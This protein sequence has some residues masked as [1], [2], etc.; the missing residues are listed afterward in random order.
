MKTK[1][2]QV[3][4]DI[5]IDF[6]LEQ[7]RE[8]PRY[9]VFVADELFTER[10]FL[11]NNDYLEEMLQIE[12]YPGQYPISVELVQPTTARLKVRNERIK[13]GPASIR[14]GLLEISNEN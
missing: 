13:L 5:F 7:D 10:T 1:F 2:V 3:L 6:D 11:W 8:H 4:L 12:A 9:R 14:K